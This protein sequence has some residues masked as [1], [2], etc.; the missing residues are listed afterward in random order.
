MTLHYSFKRSPSSEILDSKFTL[1]CKDD[2]WS[3][4]LDDDLKQHFSRLKLK[5]IK[6][7]I[8]TQSIKSKH[9]IDARRYLNE[10][11]NEKLKQKSNDTN[12]DNEFNQFINEY[13]KHLFNTSK[14]DY[15]IYKR[16]LDKL[17]E[18]LNLNDTLY[19]RFI[20]LEAQNSDE[21]IKHLNEINTNCEGK[22]L[23]LF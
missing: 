20:S 23:K 17:V 13:E 21:T 18:N 5:K 7:S 19:Q 16:E 6:D 11:L 2:W 22:F 8:L 15:V 10:T 1:R 14:N 3:D 12:F 4:L 9:R